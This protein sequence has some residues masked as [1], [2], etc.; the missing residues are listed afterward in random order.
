[1][2]KRNVFMLSGQ[3]SQYYGMATE[4]FDYHPTFKYWMFHCDEIVKPHLNT[5]LIKIIFEHSVGEFDEILYSNPALIAIQFGI[6]KVL[7]SEGIIPNA[8]IGYSLGELSA[9]AING[10]LTLNE[11]LIFSIE[12]GQLLKNETLECKMLVIIDSID[13]WASI[14]NRFPGCYLSGKNSSN[15]FVLTGD[16]FNISRMENQLKMDNILYQPLPIKIGFHSPVIDTAAPEFMR[17]SRKYHFNNNNKYH[18]I[19]SSTSEIITRFDELHYW[20]VISKIVDFEK[21][22]RALEEARNTA[23]IDLGPSGTMST[24]LKHN[25]GKQNSKSIEF[26]ETIN[27]FGSNMSS[28]NKVIEAIGK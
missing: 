26:Y 4:L 3:G 11:A 17:L 15:N 16:T 5:S 24:L 20:N 21:C 18:M 22:A 6:Y 8:L 28:I 10:T 1:M 9:A 23:F 14:Q 25:I 7:E 12:Y 27:R 13:Y 2:G 19:S